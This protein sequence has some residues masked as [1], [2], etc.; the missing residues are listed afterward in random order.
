MKCQQCGE[1]AKEIK[2]TTFTYWYCSEC[3]IEV[4]GAKPPEELSYGELMRALEEMFDEWEKDE[5]DEVPLL[6]KGCAPLGDPD[7]SSSLRK[8][9]TVTGTDTVDASHLPPASNRS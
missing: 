2:Y 9:H 6:P 7:D 5:Y 4:T 8:M 1:P 3:K